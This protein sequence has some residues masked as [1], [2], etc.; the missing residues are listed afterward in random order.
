VNTGA[1]VLASNLIQ[2]RRPGVVNE[3][4]LDLPAT[5]ERVELHGPIPAADIGAMPNE[6]LRLRLV[7]AACSAIA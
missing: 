2:I 4:A 6:V 7:F 5:R 3:D 1:P